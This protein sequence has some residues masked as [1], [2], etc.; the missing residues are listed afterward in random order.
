MGVRS[1]VATLEIVTHDLTLFVGEY[2][3]LFLG[4]LTGLRSSFSNNDGQRRCCTGKVE[5]ESESVRCLTT[6]AMWRWDMGLYC[7][8]VA[9][10][11]CA[12]MQS[13]DTLIVSVAGGESRNASSVAGTANGE[14]GDGPRVSP[15]VLR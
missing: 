12:R 1:G 10:G 13:I 14:V 5:T 2:T 7:T 6:S 8:T 9:A 4:D 15:V 3:R 11:S